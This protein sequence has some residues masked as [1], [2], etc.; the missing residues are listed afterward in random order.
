MQASL[1]DHGNI[2]SQGNFEITI[3]CNHDS[4]NGR[5]RLSITCTDFFRVNLKWILKKLFKNLKKD[6]ISHHCCRSYRDRCPRSCLVPLFGWLGI[7]TFLQ[8]YSWNFAI[9]LNVLKCWIYSKIHYR[10]LLNIFWIF[11]NKS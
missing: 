3:K 1:H 7:L 5:S 11:L 2:K 9:D 8:R 4:S 6:G 10:P